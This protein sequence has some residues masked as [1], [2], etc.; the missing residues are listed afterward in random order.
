LESSAFAPNRAAGDFVLGAATVGGL[1]WVELSSP[2]VSSS[3][4]DDNNNN[5][6]NNDDDK[7]D[8]DE[9]DGAD[10]KMTVEAG[11]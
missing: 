5:N 4:S 9:G 1:I 8:T 2:S 6:N 10:V 11:Q 3:S 7:H